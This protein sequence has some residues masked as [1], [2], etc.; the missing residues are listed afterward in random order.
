MD[1][2]PPSEPREPSNLRFLRRLVTV[3]TAVMIAGVSAIVIL[4]FMRLQS[5]TPAP[6]LPAL[7]DRITLPQDARPLAVTA[8]PGW[9][10]VVTE[11]G[12]ILVYDAA[13][14]TLRQTVEINT[15]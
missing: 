8:G 4:L 1:D 3:L 7:P 15:R 9:Y 6:R 11:A 13:S 2:N 10:A 5:E 14:G 12:R